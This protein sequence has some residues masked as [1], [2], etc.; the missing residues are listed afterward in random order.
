MRHNRRKAPSCR[1][2]HAGEKC[3]GR[4]SGWNRRK[5]TGIW[6]GR[7]PVWERLNAREQAGLA[8]HTAQVHYEKGAR[9]HGA[10]TEC[11]GVLFVMRGRLRAYMLSQE[12]VRLRST[13]WEQGEICI[14]SASCVLSEITFDVHIDAEEDTD[15][16]LTGAPYFSALCEQSIYAECFSYKLAAERFSDVM[17]A[18]QQLLFMRMDQRLAILCGMNF[19]SGQRRDPP[20][21]RA[22]CTLHGSAARL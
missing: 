18:M 17:W 12:G 10:G 16:L 2:G 1:A 11:I 20:D 9:L 7:S 4:R 6:R 14:L 22:G 5:F 3:T 21:A 19:P 13:G 8:E 15:A